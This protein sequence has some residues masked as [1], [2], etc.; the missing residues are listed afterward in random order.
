MMVGSA[1]ENVYSINHTTKRRQN[2]R[3]CNQR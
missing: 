2:L 1:G 3:N